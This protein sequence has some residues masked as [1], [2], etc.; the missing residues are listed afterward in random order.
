MKFTPTHEQISTAKAVFMA[1]AITKTIEPIVKGYEK[2]I[3]EAHQ[4]TNKGE[5]ERLK[6]HGHEAVEKIILDPKDSFL[7]SDEDFLI[8][9]A[10][11]KKERDKAKLKVESDEFCP[12]LVAEDLERKAKHCFIDAMEVTTKIKFD[13]LF[14]NFPEDYNKYLDLSL[15][16]LAPFVG[17]AKTILNN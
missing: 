4:W 6:K 13:Q 15:K 8:Y 3:L 10:E 16:L 17:N 5:V 7:L 12:L 9:D 14:K 11:C 2:K 1:M